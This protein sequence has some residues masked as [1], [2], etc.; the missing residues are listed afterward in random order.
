MSKRE[1]KLKKVRNKLPNI[2][3]FKS[4]PR[5]MK[6]VIDTKGG[7]NVDMPLIYEQK[8]PTQLLLS[9]HKRKR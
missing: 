1:K 7:P 8:K 9:L 5:R 3:L 2:S 6:S 4:I